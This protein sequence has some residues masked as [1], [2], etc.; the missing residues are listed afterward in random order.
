MAVHQPGS[1][2]VGWVGNNQPTA[3]REEGDIA[4]GRVCELQG[5]NVGSG[6]GGK[7]ASAG[8]KHIHVM[9]V[10]VDRMGNWG[11]TGGLLDDPE[12]P[13][14]DGLAEKYQGRKDAHLSRWR[15]FNK[16]IRWR[17]TRVTCR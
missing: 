2:V 7:L 15:N 16:V 13:L 11:S 10:Q 8:S 6:V 4:T 5:C 9:T 14:Q 3:T 17:I 1:R 12:C